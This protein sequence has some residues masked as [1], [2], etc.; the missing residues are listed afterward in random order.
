MA[1]AAAL[2][3]AKELLAAVP[4]L[5]QMLTMCGFMEAMECVHLLEYEHFPSLDAFGDYSMTIM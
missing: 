3:A 2:I 5:D 1:A 4:D